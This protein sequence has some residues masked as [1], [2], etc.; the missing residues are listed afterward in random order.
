MNR[1]L[2]Y[3]TILK[4]HNGDPEAMKEVLFH[5]AGYICYCSRIN[6]HLNTDME[7]YIKTKLIESQF[8]FRFDR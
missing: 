5:Y 2:P 4:A 1:L 8:K 6:G 3:E 7:D